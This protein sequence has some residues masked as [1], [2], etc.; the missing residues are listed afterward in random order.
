MLM[1]AK[2]VLLNGSSARDFV[3]ESFYF[4]VLLLSSA[5]RG[6]HDSGWTAW[7]VRSGA[8]LLVRAGDLRQG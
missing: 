1:A 4:E 2:L 8:G 5:K 6:L 3:L 7:H